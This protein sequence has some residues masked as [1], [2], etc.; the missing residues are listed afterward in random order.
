[1]RLIN[2][3]Q[4]YPT[5]STIYQNPHLK[6]V[7]RNQQLMP[8]VSYS[9]ITLYVLCMQIDLWMRWLKSQ[10]NL[11]MKILSMQNVYIFYVYM[12]VH[13]CATFIRTRLVLIHIHIFIYVG[14]A[15]IC[16]TIDFPANIQ[17]ICNSRN[18]Y[19]LSDV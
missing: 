17:W 1:M 12:L 18:L 10:C 15:G 5:S 9:T 4:I 8:N 2:Y 13:I 3:S 19:M 7:V 16:M 6:C 14:R 11:N